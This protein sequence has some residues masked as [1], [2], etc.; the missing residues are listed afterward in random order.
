MPVGVESSLL[1]GVVLGLWVSCCAAGNV[2]VAQLHQRGSKD[3]GVVVLT[4][5]GS[6]LVA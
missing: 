4:I 6:H 3:L 2:P 1:F 5:G